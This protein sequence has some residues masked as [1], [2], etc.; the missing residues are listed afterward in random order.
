MAGVEKKGVFASGIGGAEEKEE[1]EEDV[2]GAARS[3]WRA[4]GSSMTW[5]GGLAC[6]RRSGSLSSSSSSSSSPPRRRCTGVVA[7]LEKRAEEGNG[8]AC[9]VVVRERV[10]HKTGDKD[11][12]SFHGA[13][14]RGEWDQDEAEGD[15]MVVVGMEEGKK[16]NGALA[17]LARREACFF[18]WCRGGGGGRRY[19]SSSSSHPLCERRFDGCRGKSSLCVVL[20]S[21]PIPSPSCVSGGRPST[22][23]AAGLSACGGATDKAVEKW[24]IDGKG[25]GRKALRAASVLDRVEC[26]GAGMG[27]ATWPPGASRSLS[28]Y[29]K[30]YPTP[31]AASHSISALRLGCTFWWASVGSPSCGFS[32]VCQ[33]EPCGCEEG[34]KRGYGGEV[35]RCRNASSPVL[36]VG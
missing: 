8:V 26:T 15:G 3:I 20:R 9:G 17:A 11:A 13:C 10:E 6:V 21:L 25:T 23:S 12:S 16:K 32:V 34:D 30:K 28:S 29:G 24:S 2:V 4:W 5:G 36:L 19:G 14:H 22:S 18:S 1:E 31:A 35:E 27:R 33:S 7:S